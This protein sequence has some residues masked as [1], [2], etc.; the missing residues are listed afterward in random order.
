MW[1]WWSTTTSPSGLSAGHPSTAPSAASRSN[2]RRPRPWR[3]RPRRAAGRV[4]MARNASSKIGQSSLLSVSY[5]PVAFTASPDVEVRG[6]RATGGASAGL[7]GSPARPRKVGVVAAVTLATLA[8]TVLASPAGAISRPERKPDKA[9]A[10][11]T[12]RC[13]D[14]TYTFAKVKKGS[15]WGHG[16]VEAWYGSDGPDKAAAKDEDDDKDGSTAKD[17]G[18]NTAGQGQRA[19]RPS[20][21]PPPTRRRRVPRPTPSRP[22]S[23]PRRLPRHSLPPHLP[24]ARPRRL[25]RRRRCHAGGPPAAAKPVVQANRVVVVSRLW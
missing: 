23:R 12:G 13:D 16:G 25:V 4:G 10:G 11:A 17:K 15:C 14:G 21:S 2:S 22:W 19:R 7:G 18:E 5:P 24:R 8:L 6:I 3:A 20:P 1:G 9:P